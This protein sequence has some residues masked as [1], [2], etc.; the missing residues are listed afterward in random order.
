M[1]GLEGAVEVSWAGVGCLEP[2]DPSSLVGRLRR[3][4]PEGAVWIPTLT[5]PAH[6][7][8]LL[9]SPG[10]RAPFHGIWRGELFLKVDL[11]RWNG[12]SG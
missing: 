9:I 11:F 8:P 4:C 10:S 3:G 7:G 2:A 1:G 6:A 5:L 12:A